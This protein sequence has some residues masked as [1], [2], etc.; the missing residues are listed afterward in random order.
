MYFNHNYLDV[1]D[2]SLGGYLKLGR[3]GIWVKNSGSYTPNSNNI[4][5]NTDEYIRFTGVHGIYNNVPYSTRGFTWSY[6]T[7]GDINTSISYNLDKSRTSGQYTI[8]T[9]DQLPTTTSD[10]TNDSG[11]ITDAALT[12]YA[13]KTY[14]NNEIGALTIPTKTSDLTNDSGFITSSALTG[15]ASETYV[16]NAVDGLDQTLATVAKTGSYSDLSNKPDLTVYELK[17]EA[18]SGDY[19][20]LTNKPDLSIYAESAD[21]ATVATTGDYDDLTNKP[22]IPVVPTNVSAFT[23]DA[24]YI[25]SSAIPTNYV[26]TDTAQTITG[27]KTFSGTTTF[28]NATNKFTA[29]NPIQLVAPS[30]QTT[31]FT[32]FNSSNTEK[33]YLQYNSTYDGLYLGRWGNSSAAE[34]GFLSESST[35]RGYKVLVPNLTSSVAP[36]NN[37]NYITLSVNNTKADS[38]GNIS[39]AIPD[40]SNYYTKTEVDNLIPTVPTNVSAFTN[41]AGY[42]TGITD[43]MINTALGYT[44]ADAADVPTTATSTS[45]STST[46]TVTP[47]TVTLTFT[48]SDDTTENVTL[49]TGASVAT[50]TTTTTTTTLS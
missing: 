34:L 41:D 42:I 1:V 28:S 5:L 17:S 39:L 13:T 6:W 46:S 2:S 36:S 11:F 45:T 43:T 32:L 4:P 26:T 22:T 48:Y 50:S 23:N 29:R 47:T 10:L 3:D 27:N 8:A 44:A 7:N 24:G 31:G 18:F 33:G 40:V 35:N 14:V 20:D 37:V 9:V 12:D 49:M 19:D 38:S 25:T 16:D 21:L 15:L 30:G